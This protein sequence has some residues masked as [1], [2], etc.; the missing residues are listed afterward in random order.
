MK[1][2]RSILKLAFMAVFPV[3]LGGCSPS[4]ASRTAG[5]HEEKI[6]GSPADPPVRLNARWMA[7][8][9]HLFR[10]DMTT[11]STMTR[12]DLPTAQEITMGQDYAITVTGEQPDGRRELELEFLSLQLDVAMDDKYVMNFD[13]EGKTEGVA[14][15]R[16]VSSLQKIVGGKLRFV[17]SPAGTIVRMDG[18]QELMQR[19]AGAKTAGRGPAM[20][21]RF[22]N[23]ELF[24]QLIEPPFLPDR[25]VRI[26][27]NWPVRREMAAATGM[28]VVEITCTFRGWQ[29]HEGRRSA[30]LDFVGTLQ[31]RTNTD[32]SARADKPGAA[33]RAGGPGGGFAKA[34]GIGGNVLVENGKITGTTWFAPDLGLAVETVLDQ[35]YTLKTSARWPPAT[36][37]APRMS[38]T[39]I[40]QSISVKLLEISGLAKA[41]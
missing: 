4:G 1:L 6:T 22:F 31:S 5:G 25:T 40:H 13:S 8:R 33:R 16:A 36:N 14:D 24:K 39:P 2:N 19:I 18:L 21:G 34:P 28:L 17:L 27:E 10:L 37:S 41:Q 11:K 15:N 23:P 30:R 9:R 26:G 3:F 38:T 7:S 35:S 20:A 12:R 29:Q 32:L